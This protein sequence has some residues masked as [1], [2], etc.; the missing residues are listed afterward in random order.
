M[1]C[2]IRSDTRNYLRVNGKIDLAKAFA[3]PGIGDVVEINLVLHSTARFT[4]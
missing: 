3:C 2:K 4:P 1:E